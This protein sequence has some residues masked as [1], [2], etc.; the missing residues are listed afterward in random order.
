MLDVLIVQR[1][2][3]PELL[4]VPYPHFVHS[5]QDMMRRFFNRQENFI[6]SCIKPLDLIASKSNVDLLR[7][8]KEGFVGVV[9]G[10]FPA[11]DPYSC[12]VFCSGS[13]KLVLGPSGYDRIQGWET[14]LLT[15]L[16]RM[17]IMEYEIV[18]GYCMRAARTA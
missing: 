4:G 12:K 7:D 1:Q 16:F 3:R 9:L 6:P 14:K 10:P 17:K 5:F 18:P 11:F 15:R 13:E 8:V 2:E